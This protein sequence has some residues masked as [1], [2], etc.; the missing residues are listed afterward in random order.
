MRKIKRRRERGRKTPAHRANQDL[1]SLHTD[2][3]PNEQ[4]SHTDRQSHSHMHCAFRPS[5][6]VYVCVC[7]YAA[8]PKQFLV[9]IRRLE[10]ALVVFR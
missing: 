9:Q 6:C 5:V 7:V 10:T 4:R 2:F 8:D 3:K 1:F